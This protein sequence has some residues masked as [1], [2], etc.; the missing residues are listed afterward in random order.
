PLPDVAK[1][2]KETAAQ[3]KSTVTSAANPVSGPVPVPMSESSSSKLP[4][5]AAVAVGVLAVL[6]VLL[7]RRHSDED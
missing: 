4:L 3:A 5:A 2:A 7:S 1:A 6:L